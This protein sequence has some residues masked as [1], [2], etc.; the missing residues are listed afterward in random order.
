[1]GNIINRKII[2][3]SVNKSSLKVDKGKLS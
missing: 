2:L 3:K 1:M